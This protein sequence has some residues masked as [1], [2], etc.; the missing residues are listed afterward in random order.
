MGRRPDGYHEIESFMQKVEL[1]DQ[2]HFFT[3][4][5]KISLA[6]PGTDLP[7]DE[8]NIVF[9][10]AQLFFDTVGKHPGVRIVLEK[11]IPV[12]A[13]LGGGSSD[14]AAVL[15][16]LNSLFAGDLSQDQLQKMALT[17]GADVPFFVNPCSGAIA[18]GIGERLQATKPITDIWIILVNPGFAVS[19]KWVYENLPLT[20]NTNPYILAR[21]R[22]LPDDSFSTLLAL[23]NEQGNDLEA[24]TIKRYPEIGEI[25]ETLKQAGAAGVLMSGSGPTVFGLFLSRE[26]ASS[27]LGIFARKYGKNVFLTK[28]YLP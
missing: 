11:K 17:L 22:N 19:T 4:G 10:A 18:A 27:C 2:L 9:K 21:G 16:G 3:E 20:T 15:H 24:V 23:S 26:T 28:P 25:K 13:G 7:E 1:A 5:E 14:A 6:C 8:G 12:A